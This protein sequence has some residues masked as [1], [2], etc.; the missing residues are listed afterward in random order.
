MTWSGAPI[1]E[2]KGISK[3]FKSKTSIAGLLTGRG[4]RVLRAVRDVSL[5][6]RAGETL[7][8]VGESGCGKSTLGRCITGFYKPDEG[9]VLYAGRPFLETGTRLERSRAIQ[10]IFQDPYSSL[11]PRMT[12]AQALDE[13][14]LVHGLRKGAGE[15]S[16]RVDE[17]MDTVGLS[18]AL[19]HRLP[20]ALSG[21]Q[22]QRF[23][24]ARA[25]AVE[26][27]ILV[28][29]E[30]VSALDASVQAQIINLFVELRERLG[31]AYIFIAHDLDVV[32]YVSQRIGVM[33]LGQIVE[34]ADAD[35]IF[36]SPGHPYTRGLLSAI[37]EANP[38]HRR[39]AA[40]I[41][42][43]LP[44]PLS[45]PPGCSFSTRCPMA[46]ETCRS[47]APP[48]RLIAG[49]VVRCH[50]GEEVAAMSESMRNDNVT[51]T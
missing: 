9:E 19:K 34:L 25:L 46:V 6:L 1:L 13:V 12:L 17:L 28:A 39:E 11:N 15:R 37:P 50:R 21:G 27:R 45:P 43:D 51:V 33:Y 24:I 26:P 49:H 42:G 22:R 40:S 44:D 29:D 18:P 2:L 5:T 31:L 38:E 23:S 47:A 36:E 32:R 14:L 20:H 4:T 3:S 7:G 16:S 48:A 10:M 8:I 30:P 35:S 41:E